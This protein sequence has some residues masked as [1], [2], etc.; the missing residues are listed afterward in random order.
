[1][2]CLTQLYAGLMPETGKPD[3]NGSYFIPFGRKGLP[4]SDTASPESGE[5]L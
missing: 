3:I 4:R 5:K 2:G 1:M